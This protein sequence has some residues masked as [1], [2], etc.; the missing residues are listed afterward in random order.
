LIKRYIQPGR[1]IL[2][3]CDTVLPGYLAGLSPDEINKS[4]L[5]HP[6]VA[7][8]GYALAALSKW[9]PRK[10]E[11]RLEKMETELMPSRVN[12]LQ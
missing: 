3:F 11:K 5:N 10:G 9:R 12:V 1:K 8:L 4:V 2:H 6:P 7:A